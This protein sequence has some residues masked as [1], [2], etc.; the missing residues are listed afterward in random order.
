MY[1][2]KNAFKCIGRSKG[3]N[4]LIGIIV[5]V[6]AV[7]ACIGLSIRQAAEN[8]RK[9]TLESLSVTATISFDRRNAMSSMRPEG[10][11]GQNSGNGG[12]DR[13]QFAQMMGDSSALTLEEYQ[14]YSK[15]STVKDFY[16]SATVSIN[17]NDNFKAVTNE[18]EEESTENNMP[19]FGG[20]SGGMGGGF[21]RI[22]GG[23]SDFTI[24]GYSGENAMTDI[25][26]GIITVTEGDIFEEGTEK[27]QCIISSELATFNDLSVGDKVKVT[28]P[29]N[30]EE[31]YKLTIVG[32]Y[33]DSS[34][35]ENSFSMMGMTST[36]PANKI[37]MSYNALHKIAEKSA[38][39]STTKTDENTGREFETKLNETI[40]AT[41]TFADV[42]AYETFETEVYTL[43]LDESYTVSS[44]DITSFEN[45]LTPLNTL[46]TTAGYFLIVIIAIGAVILIVLNIFNVRERKYEIGVLTAMGMKK[47]K[48]ALQFIA[49]IFAV[50]IIAVLIGAVVGAASSVPVTNAL[51]AGQTASQD[52]RQQEI[53]KNFGRGDMPS[54][55]PNNVPDFGG[56]NPFENFVGNAENYITEID[57]ATNITVL[58]QML[59]IAVLLT[60][61]AGAASMLFIMRYEPLKILSNR[62]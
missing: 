22:M 7:S 30:E 17:G 59:G 25:K 4:V 5:L 8:A 57:S 23:Q 38:K 52:N 28:N 20:M 46:S 51:L 11:D 6:I 1:I 43:G 10:G 35:N 53:E 48:V 37:Y 32:L 58:L 16:Y 13:E 31:T 9:E 47:S 50:T 15:A 2:L 33:E 40:D 36:D 39:N 34:S 18:Q 14:K 19:S 45:S 55:M 56:K 27:Y 21:N 62:D 60:V 41:Y 61:F 42:E 54:D 44:A 26:D 24:I 12:F 49:E 3:R 29:N